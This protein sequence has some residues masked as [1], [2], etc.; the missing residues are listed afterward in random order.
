MVEPVIV[1]GKRRNKFGGLGH[2]YSQIML[3]YKILKRGFVLQS[4]GIKVVRLFL[5]RA[6]S[7][8]RGK[9]GRCSVVVF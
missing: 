9:V 7:V 2:K 3:G 6:L 4:A 5:R 1:M 8:G